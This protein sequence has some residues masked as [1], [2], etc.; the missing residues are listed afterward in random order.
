MAGVILSLLWVSAVLGI[1]IAVPAWGC[2]QAEPVPTPACTA[3]GNA[4]APG[5]ACGHTPG[6]GWRTKAI[7]HLPTEASF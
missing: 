3:H 7:F 4:G 6:L 2:V 1:F 5:L